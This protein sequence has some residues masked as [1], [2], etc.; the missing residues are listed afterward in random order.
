MPLWSRE[1]NFKNHWEVEELFIRNTLPWI[2]RLCRHW[3]GRNDD[4]AMPT[5][6]YRSDDDR[7]TYY[8]DFNISIVTISVF[9]SFR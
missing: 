6:L 3:G 5:I 4:K 7:R 2:R 9:H 8:P 1:I